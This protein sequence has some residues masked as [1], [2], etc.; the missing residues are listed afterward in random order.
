MQI[1]LFQYTLYV[2]YIRSHRSLCSVLSCSLA[3]IYTV[4]NNNSNNNNNTTSIVCSH[5]F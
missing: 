2:P 1:D 3:F 5:S 4:I